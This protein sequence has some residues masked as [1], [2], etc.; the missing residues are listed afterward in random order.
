MGLYTKQMHS[1]IY[2][3]FIKLYPIKLRKVRPFLLVL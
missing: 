3:I 1:V 2:G